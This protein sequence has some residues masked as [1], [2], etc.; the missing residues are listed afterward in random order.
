MITGKKT[1]PTVIT[2]FGGSGDLSKRKL[3]PAFYNLFIDGWMPEQFAI[4]GLGLE[5]FTD[6]QYH[7][8]V[9]KGLEQFSRNGKPADDTWT[10]FKSRICYVPSNMNEESTYTNLLEKITM[11]DTKWGTRADRLFYLSI[12]P[13]FVEVV[14]IN[15]HKLGIAPNPLTDRLIIEKP[16][17]HNK[18]SAVAL[19]SLL[20][21]LY[22][23]NQLYRININWAKKRYR[24]TW[25]S[26]L[27]TRWSNPCGTAALSTMCR[28]RWRSRWAWKKGAAIM[29]GRALCAI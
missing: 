11:W 2:I 27:P 9:L 14:A 17:G 26:V 18:A 4:I 5:N 23:E 15:L 25:L 6:D 1:T 20:T 10:N 3:L 21:S 28:S 22:Q 19:S 24:I 29:K 13:K 16:F 8:F 7:D 12:A